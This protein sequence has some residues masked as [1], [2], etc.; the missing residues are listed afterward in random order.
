[1]EMAARL[2]S[3]RVAARRSQ[4]PALDQESLDTRRRAWRRLH[5]A[6][7]ATA[8]DAQGCGCQLA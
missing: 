7:R 3:V 1:M 2:R 5:D 6:P 4:A 8:I